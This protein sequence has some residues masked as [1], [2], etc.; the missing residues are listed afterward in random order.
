MSDT[1]SEDSQEPEVTP[2]STPFAAAGSSAESATGSVNRSG[3]AQAPTVPVEAGTSSGIGVEGA[4][5]RLID[6]PVMSERFR[7]Y[8]VL[9]NLLS[10]TR[11]ARRNRA[12]ALVAEGEAHTSA[13][14]ALVALEGHYISV[15]ENRQRRLSLVVCVAVAALLSAIDALPAWWASQALGG[16]LWETGLVTALLVAALAGFAALL[17]TF[18][19]SEQRTGFVS[20]VVVSALL[21][22]LETG[23]RT[24][25]L[26][27]SKK[28]GWT[29]WLPDVA[30]LA[31]VTGG[32]VWVS[33]AILV[34]AESIETYRLRRLVKQLDGSAERATAARRR[35][36][37]VHHEKY[38]A[39]AHTW[40]SQVQMQDRKS[41]V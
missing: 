32:L 10:D 35:N 8:V 14:D 39:L 31:L 2:G 5:E 17:S 13:H 6:H 41:V 40:K 26:I 22:A 27:V 3:A 24:Q 21:V 25:F 11:I 33:Y 34:R 36:E 19:H 23:L 16:G 7:P 1:A 12:R 38:T 28:D 4:L 29:E 37:R 20:A 18:K 30:M 9:R 15:D